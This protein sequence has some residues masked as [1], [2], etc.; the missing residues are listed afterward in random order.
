M[1]GTPIAALV[2]GWVDL[3]TLAVALE[4]PEP[5]RLRRSAAAVRT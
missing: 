1:N 2:H 5:T 4:R 3:Y